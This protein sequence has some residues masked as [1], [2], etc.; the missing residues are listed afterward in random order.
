MA[1]RDFKVRHG[2][3]VCGNTSLGGDVAISGNLDIGGNVSLESADLSG[4]LQVS[5]SAS[6]GGST[7]LKDS[8]TV[9]GLT[10]LQG[11][12]VVD[13]S[14]D[15]Q[16]AMQANSISA[17][18]QLQVD[19][20]TSLKNTLTVSGM[21]SLQG[22]LV[23]D[24]ESDFQ[25]KISANQIS[26][27]GQLTVDQQV[28]ADGSILAGQVLRAGGSL[29]AQ[30]QAF[31]NQDL[32]VTGN[33]DLNG[34]LT[35]CGD[36]TLS[37]TLQVKGN[38]S[39]S[40]TTVLTGGVQALSGLDVSGNV[41]ATGHVSAG[42]FLHAGTTLQVSGSA[43]IGSLK[44]TGMTSLQGG[45]VVDTSMDVQ[46]TLNA[47]TISAS[48]QV[49]I[50]GQTN[51]SI[52]LQSNTSGLAYIDFGR[53]VG[54]V[55]QDYGGRI[56]LDADTTLSICAQQLHFSGQNICLDGTVRST[57]DVCFQTTGYVKQ[58][59][60]VGQNTGT[61]GQYDTI[62]VGERRGAQGTGDGYASITMSPGA[63][64]SKMDATTSFWS[65]WTNKNSVAS[66][67]IRANFGTS[68]EQIRLRPRGQ[69]VLVAS[70]TS[71]GVRSVA[72]CGSL[73][74][75][76]ATSLGSLKVAGTTCLQAA[77]D[78]NQTLAVSGAISAPGG[79]HAVAGDIQTSGTISGTQL[80]FV[81]AG[82][83]RMTVSNLDS[84]SGRVGTLSA[85][86]F[87]WTSAGGQRITISSA[88][89]TSLNVSTITVNQQG[90][91]ARRISGTVA[92]TN[93]GYVT[94]FTVNGNNLASC[95]EVFFEGTINSVVVACYAEIIANHSGD[96]TIRTHQ[97]NYTPLD[98][99]VISN[100]N[101]DFAVLVKRNG[102]VAG[103]ANLNFNVYPKGDET[104][105]ATAT[106]PYS[107]TTFTH[108]GVRGTKITAT[109]GNTHRF[110]TNGEIIGK[111]TLTVSGLTSLQ[112]GLVVDTSMDVQVA[113]QMDNISSSGTLKVQGTTTLSG[114]T[115]IKNTLSVAGSTVLSG[116]VQAK[117]TLSVGGSQTIGGTTW[118]NGHLR[119]GDANAGLAMDPNEI[120]FAGAGNL[121]TLSGNLQ[122]NPAGSIV[123]GKVFDSTANIQTTAII[124]GT[125][126]RCTSF[127]GTTADI[128]G[129]L[130]VS[131][132]A[133][134][135]S[136]RVAGDCCAQGGL[137]VQGGIALTGELDF[138]G[139]T[140][141]YVDFMLVSSNAAT[142]TAN[143]RS[144]DH[145][146]QNHH[147][148]LTLVR[149]GAVQLAYNNNTKAA[150]TNT[151]FYVSGIL[152]ATLDVKVG[153]DLR[154]AGAISV[155]GAGHIANQLQVGQQIS[156]GGGIRAAQAIC[157]GSNIIAGDAAAG[158][159]GLSLND[160]YGNAN[161][162]FN[163]H[164]GIPDV[165]G[166][167]ARIE[168]NV[169][170]TTSSFITLEVGS[171]LQAQTAQA[172]Q[173]A[174][175]FYA[176]RTEINGEL[177]ALGNTSIKGTLLVSGG[178]TFKSG[179]TVSG[180]LS[181]RKYSFE[182][183]G[184]VPAY[185]SN[186]Y[187]T[188]TYNSAE[189]AIELSSGS[190]TSI[191]MA[192]PAWKVNV[193]SGNKWEITIQI[194]ASAATT[195]GIYIRLYEYDA[196][197]PDGKIAVSDDA[198]N[199][200][201]QEDTRRK[202]TSPQYENQA[203]STTWK[204]LT[205]EYTPT[206]TAVWASIVVL[207][208]T[209][210]GTNALYVREPQIK[211]KL[212]KVPDADT[213]DGIDSGSFLRS[214]V[215]DSSSRMKTFYTNM[216]SQDDWINSPISIIE[217]GA[218]GSG[219]GEDRDSPNLNFHWNGR[220]SNSLWMNSG[221]VLNWGS[222][223]ASGVPATDG[224]F[225][226]GTIRSDNITNRTGQQLI[227]NAG[228]SSGKVGGQ[229]AELVYANAEGGFRVSCP[230]GSHTNWDSGYTVDYIQL[231][232]NTMSFYQGMASDGTGAVFKQQ[233]LHDGS[234][235]RYDTIGDL[236]IT[237]DGRL[238]MH[239][240]GNAGGGQNRFEGL[241]AASSAN[242][243]SQFILSSSYSDLVI[244]SSQV[245]NNH[246]S[247]L[248]FATYNPSNAG[249]YNKFVVNQ[250][251]WG[252]RKQFLDFG[253]S[254]ATNRTN[255]H[256]NINSTDTVL[257]LDG[258]NK[259]VGIKQI[260]PAYNLDVTGTTRVT[261]AVTFSSTLA[262]AG[263]TTF[264]SGLIVEGSIDSGGAD[265]AGYRSDSTNIVLKGSSTGVSGIF[266][267]S[268]KNGTN[269]NHGS[270]YGY[271]QY[272]AHGIDGTSG[273]SCKLVIGVAN[274]SADTVVLQ[275]P[276]KDGVKISYKNAT[277]GTGG[278]EYTVWHAGNDGAGSGLD[279]DNLD[280]YTWT[281]SGKNIRGTNIYADDW[282]RNYNAGEG[283]YNE[284]TGC[285]FVSDGTDQ[286]TVRDGGNSIRIEFKTNGTTR[287]ASVYADNGPS[288]GFLNSANQW[289][290]R[291]LSNDGNSPNLY[292]REEGNESWTGNPGDDIGKIEYHANRFY[293]AAGANSNRV[294][295][296]RRSGSDVGYW[297][298]DGNIYATSS[299]HK[300]WHAGNDA[301]G[302][303]L[304]ADLL[305]G[306]HLSGSTSI[307]D[308][309]FNNKGR[310]H[311][312]ITD[313]N[314]SMTPGANYLQGG[315]NGPTGTSTHQWY[316][317]MLGL[318]SEYGTTTGTAGHYASQ[319]Y[320]GRQASGS[321]AYL[322]ARDMEGGT[323][324]SW[325]KFSAGN[326]DTLGGISPGSFL[327]SDA[328]D[329][330]DGQVSGRYLRFRCVDGRLANSTS[331]G[332]FPLEIYQNTVNTDAAIAFH[333]GND[334]AAY[335]GLDGTTNDLFWGGWSRGAAKYK[336]WHAA[337]DGSGSG[338]DADLLDGHHRD[339][340]AATANTVA[341]RNGSGDI[342]C[343][344]IRQTYGNQSTI[345][346]GI[347]YRVNNSN[348]NY[349]RV[350]SDKSAIRTF[351]GANNAS[352]LNTG[353]IPAARVAHNTFDIGDT[354]AEINRDVHETGIYTFNVNNNNLGTGTQTAY[355]SVL[356]FGQGAGGSAQIA[357]KW[358]SS[359]DKL[360]YR[361]LRDTVDNWWSWREIWHSG[362]KI[363]YTGSNDEAIRLSS[364]DHSS[365]SLYL[366]GWSTANNN[367]IH[368]I[369]CS[370]NLHID[371]S[372]DSS[373]LMQW[374]SQRETQYNGPIRMRDSKPIY[375]GTGA[376]YRIWHDGTNHIMRNYHHAS[377]NVYHQGENTSGTNQNTIVEAYNTART[378]LLLYENN[379]ERLR[380]V[381]TG[382]NVNGRINFPANS[383]DA[384]FI[385]TTVSGTTTH[386][387]FYLSDDNNADTFRWRFNPS[388]GN[389]Y[390]AM[391]LKPV[392]T[393][394]ARLELSGDLYF[395]NNALVSNDGGTSNLDHIWHN[396]GE[397]SW[398]FCSDTTYKATGNSRI[399]C[400]TI[401]A[402]GELNLIGG[403][404]AN[405]Y[406]DVR[407]GGN[408]FHIRK[409]TGGD[410]G[411]EVMAH[412]H[413]D[414]ECALY[415]NGSN[416]FQTTSSG[417][418]I[419]GLL[420]LTGSLRAEAGDVSVIN[421]RVKSGFWQ[422]S[423][424]AT[425]D[426]WP[427]NTSGSSNWYHLL[428]STHSNTS[429]YYAMQ[430]AASFFTQSLL[431]Y[432]TTNGNGNT[433][434]NKVWHA[435]S[436][437]S[438]SGLDA[439]TVDGVHG[440]SFLRS[441]TSDTATGG[442]LTLRDIQSKSDNFSVGAGAI[443]YRIQRS[444]QHSLGRNTAAGNA[445]LKVF[446]GVGEFRV[447]GDG[448]CQNTGNSYSG[449]SDINLKENIVDANSQWDD[450]KDIRVRNYNFRSSTGISTHTQ[451]G[452][453]AQEIELVSPGLVKDSIEEDDDGNVIET[454]KTV[455]YS[456]LYMKAV[457]ALQ[458]AMDRIETLEAKV[459]ALESGT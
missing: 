363:I 245:N 108:T 78:I 86:K 355:Y 160:G 409:T 165:A 240:D 287:R 83:Q 272:H 438:G 230:D 14:L 206:S 79:I 36:T 154:A 353:T 265:Y 196:E 376:D 54:G 195:N 234:H 222:Y 107:G 320:W 61:V 20:T 456:V 34:T 105:T 373:L 213:L 420:N 155:D 337:N 158:R 418:N 288:I 137:G 11:G 47:D 326:S 237:P 435:G 266:F 16:S 219:D 404:D 421:T 412:F 255:P 221:G 68:T 257:T 201:V 358:T 156:V 2:L 212:V 252:T 181:A 176:N 425:A 446:G 330:Y 6:I 379:E 340:G 249:E 74:V 331:G 55:A 190:D 134:L 93:A 111:Q 328:W 273:E 100:N 66:E 98:I 405:K 97:G 429:N 370:T 310:T 101:E 214:D 250:G 364:S 12:L 301:S 395:N 124:S 129:T 231:T 150:T 318:G 50:G 419:N 141:K 392:S 277:S 247:T 179:L 153:R 319:F 7:T 62:L 10:S 369:R 208:W 75:S 242:G 282:F 371:S 194:R 246:G 239:R 437:G 367:N 65:V 447:K 71:A 53:Q 283:L 89:I 423:T 449:I 390:N 344:L 400:G 166:N 300:V 359:G 268:E 205:F 191:G 27:S 109:G 372:S 184:V 455:A 348:D 21:T 424:P 347:V 202:A 164:A 276:Y 291:Y 37:S 387:D 22:G 383:T 149:G 398:N 9:S 136:L 161:I 278:T 406:M 174:A 341:G 333:I 211:Q 180:T 346:G 314:T 103:T 357:A 151:G 374:Y 422:H 362:T 33:S 292:F 121:G 216:S 365:D 360:Y 147:T 345:S 217:R 187:Q 3:D 349:L 324:G 200:L 218:A 59:L 85:T 203:G 178:G 70:S 56:I 177:Q 417:A 96:I 450:I 260:N 316:G 307:S 399:N 332:L 43:S 448:D 188:I 199:A 110:E 442:T 132:S 325:R 433:G 298:N 142:F 106:N 313:F 182:P 285:H 159:I 99:Q 152:S 305:D 64:G 60:A 58:G 40:G 264:N 117:N 271:I 228:E 262:I 459:A 453:I 270:D 382:I 261:G 171:G 172:L 157:S 356:A 95:I 5:G 388:G 198:T 4:S 76:G 299:N 380:T 183:Y 381:S 144:M 244:A 454:R 386:L 410:A 368:R 23:V 329:Q 167:A 1:N 251:N 113:A 118:A 451:I 415:Y 281:S 63:F 131:G 39:I 42:G 232:R 323:W 18:G 225:A 143:F 350:C 302:S 120:Y 407:V 220:V 391:V 440:G 52:E 384:A 403:S 185:S 439:D 295:Q 135:G 296:F 401:V 434:W 274:D 163:H 87:N 352:N 169:D 210:L 90:N 31:V 441:D 207:N 444:G 139:A 413:G 80:K 327:R 343:R 342:H 408:I 256:S 243:R 29:C 84:V 209:G 241:T 69:D 334:Y 269:I 168:T 416:K 119:L 72:I 193:N 189:S 458:E 104:V 15:V 290:L 128:A 267:Q 321:N 192:F 304:D 377:G 186:A 81:S 396:D 238:H 82:G 248:T 140:Q 306:Y 445:V 258:V 259:R 41:Q 289:G 146:G 286:W 130:Q 17:S 115:Q 116:A 279:A 297:A 322:W 430:F 338:L 197:L 13:T 57:G 49:V 452:V 126:L 235:A 312:T 24:G 173:T 457:K 393:Y 226:V 378:Y 293:I 125:Q 112:G 402:S 73:G 263:T 389:E 77:V 436:D 432:R 414:A 32:R 30:A 45:L 254:T 375:F 229:T 94:A 224:Q 44:V 336:I 114:S 123:T 366:G 148:H 91:I 46:T 236:R 280:G 122:L 427:V 253:Y 428:S 92:S 28:Q 51:P 431:Y 138:N 284:A 411:H 145:N 303:G 25:A 385:R 227:L 361:S 443:G 102:G 162:T 335:F 67:R 170:S 133:S 308:K 35:V 19:G 8:L 317:F 48:G 397:N 394:V 275:S 309:I 351:I 38:A 311:S 88:T 204:T 354:T 175:T 426:G 223:N 215:A 315:T 127:A 26:A 339:S 233:I 294:C